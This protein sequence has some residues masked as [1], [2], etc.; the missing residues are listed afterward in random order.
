MSLIIHK[1]PNRMWNKWR[2]YLDL[3]RVWDGY[4]WYLLLFSDNYKTCIFLGVTEW[5]LV[6]DKQW[7]VG[8]VSSFY[9]IGLMI[10][11]FVVGYFSDRFGRKPVML[12]LMLLSLA[13]TL[14]GVF[15]RGYWSYAF[16][17]LVTGVAAQVDTA[18]LLF[19][20][21]FNKDKVFRAF[22][23]LDL[24]FVLRL[25]DAKREFLFFPG[26]LTRT[27]W[28]IIFTFLILWVKLF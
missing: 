11:S 12:G 1:W 21:Y 15:C 22:S 25:L 10:G 18:N 20:N 4:F 3:W 19:N 14:S 9:M 23:S 16:T 17:R 13:S 2:Q 7:M 27:S 5:D 8:M 6:C 28:Q 26:S 24:V